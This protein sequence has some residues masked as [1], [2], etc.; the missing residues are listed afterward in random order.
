[1]LKER[2]KMFVFCAENHINRYPFVIEEILWKNT[3]F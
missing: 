2:V 1:M 3:K